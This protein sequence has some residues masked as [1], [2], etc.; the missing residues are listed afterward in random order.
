MLFQSDVYY[1]NAVN[2]Y[3]ATLYM[4][5]ERLVNCYIVA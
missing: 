5:F 3:F 4:T 1:N 2:R